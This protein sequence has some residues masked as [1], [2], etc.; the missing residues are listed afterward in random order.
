MIT[1]VVANRAF[2]VVGPGGTLTTLASVFAQLAVRCA[3]PPSD[4]RCQS[5]V[6]G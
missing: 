6:R 4:K 2:Y 1:R 3:G 5:C